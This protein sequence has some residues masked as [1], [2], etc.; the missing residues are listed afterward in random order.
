[1]NLSLTDL[2]E[3]QSQPHVPINSNNALIETAV[4]AIGDADITFV[5]DG[6]GV[7]LTTGVKLD[8]PVDF[9]CTIVAATLLADQSGSIVLDLWKDTYA[10]FPPTGADSICA[11]A[12]PT[13]SAAVKA[14]DTTLT[15]WTTSIAAGDILRLNVDSVST[16]TRVTLALKVKKV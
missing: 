9:A 14:K 4:N 5:L 7:A 16:V 11:S 1:M 15:G 12:K 13:L 8:I 2:E 3:N 6:G 10:N